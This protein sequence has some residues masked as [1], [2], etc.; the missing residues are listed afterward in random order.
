MSQEETYSLL[1]VE[2]C[3]IH[4]LARIRFDY[5]V[6]ELV[7]SMAAVGQ[8]QPGRALRVAGNGSGPQYLVYIGCRRLIACQKAGIKQFKALVV[9][10]ADDSRIQ[11]ELLTENMKRAN[12]SVLEELNLL[13]NYSKSSYSL[14]DLAKDMGFSPRLVRGRVNLAIQL[15]A[16]GLIETFYR[17]ERVSGFRFT[18][19]HIEEIAALEEDRWL[20][21]AIQAAEHNWKAEQ[22]GT[23]GGKFGLKYLVDTLPGWGRQFVKQVDAKASTPIGAAASDRVN[24][25]LEE[26][27][28]SEVTAPTSGNK[29]ERP[30]T[31]SHSR[32]QTVTDS[33]RYLVCPK[34]GTET[35]VEFPTYPTATLFLPGKVNAEGGAVPLHKE[36]IPLVAGLSS[37]RCTNK[38]C[39]R[40]LTFAQDLLG[41]GQ[42]LLRREELLSLI[43]GALE[44][45]DG[46]IGSLVWDGK[47]ETWLKVQRNDQGEATYLA[48]SEKARRW[49]I[50]VKI[51][52]RARVSS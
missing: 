22:I 31:E 29:Q 36:P 13:A 48:Y 34:C 47:D 26:E 11:R 9:N 14:D 21:I 33:S 5:P 23:L 40:T 18:H 32:Y 44:P 12:L 39:G 8:V 25:A 6:D 4:P 19:R 45:K 17:I 46:G 30:I 50:P 38:E 41:D 27:R 49:V 20:P 24:N 1:P 28:V 2:E 52:E 16:K 37:L 7:E 3:A 15:Q 43:S 51:G 35:P 42:P 10:A